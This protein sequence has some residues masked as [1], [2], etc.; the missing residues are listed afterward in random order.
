MP[1]AL[2][3]A[4]QSARRPLIEYLPAI[5]QQQDDLKTFI[6][7]FDKRFAQIESVLDGIERNFA[8]SFAPFDD[9]LPWLAQ[10]VGHVF[11]AE[12]DEDR[13]R[14][15]LAQAMELY[16]WRGTVAGLKRYI[17]LWLDVRSEEVEILERRRPGGMQ[18]GVASRIG[19]PRLP[20]S[21]TAQPNA[22]I[23]P[24][25]HDYY[26]VDTAAASDAEDPGAQ[27]VERR[28]ILL[29]R[30]FRPAHRFGK[31]DIRIFY[32]PPKTD[33]PQEASHPR[34]PISPGGEHPGS[35]S[36]RRIDGLTDYLAYVNRIAGASEPADSAVPCDPAQ[37]GEPR[38][39][40]TLLIREVPQPYT[41][42]CL[43]TGLRQQ[44]T[45]ADEGA[46]A[47]VAQP[48]RSRKTLAYA[49]LPAR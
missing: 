46:R 48:A 21:A 1:D 3:K 31:D 47:A 42:H 2:D 36:V 11:D 44:G 27:A 45:T 9:F 24:I 43:D 49:V 38:F 39:G 29:R 6:A 26:V 35:P 17:E 23:E 37:P 10:C 18:I 30:A 13:R 19:Q 33:R 20:A 4:Y 34:P 40:G 22:E 5:F 12:W 16:R 32:W 25:A 41:L 7:P 14:R 8:V 15:F 28:R